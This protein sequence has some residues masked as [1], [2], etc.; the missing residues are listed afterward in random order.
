MANDPTS[1]AKPAARPGT[2]LLGPRDLAATPPD[3]VDPPTP[4]S[5]PASHSTLS[6][7]RPSTVQPRP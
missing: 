3:G 7:P 6:P 1:Q 2:Y 5:S 4:T